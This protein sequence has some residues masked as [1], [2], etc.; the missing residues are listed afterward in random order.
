MS[1]SDFADGAPTSDPEDGADTYSYV[2]TRFTDSVFDYQFDAAQQRRRHVLKAGAATEDWAAGARRIVKWMQH[3]APPLTLDE[4]YIPGKLSVG[5]DTPLN[6]TATWKRVASVLLLQQTR[7]QRQVSIEA[8]GWII[9]KAHGANEAAEFH[10]SAALCTPM[11]CCLLALYYWEYMPTGFLFVDRRHNRRR[12]RIQWNGISLYK[13]FPGEECVPL[14]CVSPTGRICEFRLV[15]LPANG[16]T[17]VCSQ[18]ASYVAATVGMRTDNCEAVL[19]WRPWYE[20][21]FSSPLVNMEEFRVVRLPG[22]LEA[23]TSYSAH[24]E[25]ERS[26]VSIRRSVGGSG[27]D[28]PVVEIVCRWS[29]MNPQGHAEEIRLIRLPP[30]D[31]PLHGVVV[32]VLK[33]VCV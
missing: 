27:I 12:L 22:F 14:V 6:R 28:N 16:G 30:T 29:C 33:A 23:D 21:T 31:D 7:F 25:T 2:S 5:C 20:F 8:L 32:K 3:E 17:T 13:P 11:Q 18:G 9:E 26:D 19:I 15:H 24:G 1:A 4:V 10:R